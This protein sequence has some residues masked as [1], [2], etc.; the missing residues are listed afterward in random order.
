[1]TD[2][3]QTIRERLASLEPK[4]V[5]LL[6]ESGRHVGHAGYREGQSTH[7][8]LTIV[9]DCFR[10]MNRIERHRRVYEALGNLMQNEIHALAVRALTP[11]EIS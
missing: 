2:V 11:D 5:E 4:S 3:A 6:D 7:F 1:M 8:R 9:S 10:G